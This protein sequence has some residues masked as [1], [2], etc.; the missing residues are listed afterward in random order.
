[1]TVSAIMRQQAEPRLLKTADLLERTG[2]SHQVLYTYVTLGLI[3][4][5]V[6][7]ESG[8]R[9]FHPSAVT[10]VRLIQSL[11]ESGYSLRD[12]K[13]IYFKDKRVQRVLA[14]RRARP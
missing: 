8:Q 6:T 2:I 3:E 10:L 11:K 9:L 1:M 5:A 13:D 4:P 12:M 7:S 14:G